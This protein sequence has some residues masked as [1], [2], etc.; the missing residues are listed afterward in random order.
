VF[1]LIAAA[2]SLQEARTLADQRNASLAASSAE[3]KVARAGSDAA[4]QLPNPTLSVSYGPDDPRLLAGLDVKLP[5]LGQRGA[6]IDSADAV[7]RVAEAEHL[8]A[9]ALLHANIRR[10]YGALWAAL[11]QVRVAGEAARLASELLRL[12]SERFKTGGA[13]Q[14]DVAQA[15][16]ADR[17]SAQELADRQAE[18]EATR[19]ELEAAVGAEVSD[20]SRPPEPAVPD[21]RELLGRVAGHPEIASLQSQ[22]AAALARAHE[23]RVSLRPLPVVTVTAERFSDQTPTWGARVGVAFDLPLLSLNQGRIQQQEESANKARLLA[24][25][26]LQKLEGQLG[27]ARSRWAAASSRAAFYGGDFLTAAQRVL[28]MS[29]TGYRIG[30]TSLFQVLQARTELSAA[31]GRAV[32]AALDAQRALADLEEALG[33]DL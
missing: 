33:A 19:R 25:A 24:T 10:A 4:G 20:V 28:E 18:A 15:E 29:E 11:E 8:A 23:E 32:D 21:F 9:K 6:A 17:R 3:V 16:L 1:L 5:I 31:R 12:T 14:L 26:Q 2:L 13:P 7:T 30:R 27:A 22:E